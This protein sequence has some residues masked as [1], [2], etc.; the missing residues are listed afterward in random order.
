MALAKS[1]RRA[2][3]PVT[4]RASSSQAAVTTTVG[5][6]VATTGATS[7][8][9]FGY[10]EAQANAIVTNVNALRVD[11]LAL[12]TLVN[13]LRSELVTLDILKGSA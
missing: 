6:A 7:S 1:L 3:V 5:S 4:R 11:V 12:T 8:T 13:Q 10:A 2:G 9:P